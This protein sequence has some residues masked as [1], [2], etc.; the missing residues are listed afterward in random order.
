MGLKKYN[1]SV[2]SNPRKAKGSVQE[3]NDRLIRAFNRKY[4][5][6]GIVK[7][8]REKVFPLTRGM[9]RRRKIAAGKRR[10]QKNKRN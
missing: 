1:F 4:K 3:Q 10:A 7:E 5:K 2:K 8:L 6:S 9:K